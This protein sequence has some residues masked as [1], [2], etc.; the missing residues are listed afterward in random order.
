MR[1]KYFALLAAVLT[2]PFFNSQSSFNTAVT[3]SSITPGFS[4]AP[5]WTLGLM[6]RISPRL[7]AGVDVGYGTYDTSVNFIKDEI[8]NKY[9]GYKSFEVKPELYYEILPEKTTEK[10][11]QL[12]SADFSY[13][14]HASSMEDSWYQN[15]GSRYSFDKADYLRMRYGIN[16]N[17]NLIIRPV[18]RFAVIPKAGVGIKHRKVEFSNVV[19]P[20]LYEDPVLQLALVPRNS[21]AL[22]WEGPKTNINF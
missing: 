14:K 5:R 13:V 12:V 17:Y 16:I 9:I 4:Y 22:H 18:K 8:S 15:R 7:I 2:A 1:K 6:Q 21:R 3:V 11:M 10:F 20:Q 19:N